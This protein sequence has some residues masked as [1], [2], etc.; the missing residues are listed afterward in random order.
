MAERE[1][2]QADDFR[3]ASGSLRVFGVVSLLVAAS[4]AA[5]AWWVYD[6]YIPR[7]AL[8]AFAMSLMV[9]SG[10]PAIPPS[11]HQQISG[12]TSLRLGVIEL[13][14]HIWFGM[15]VVVALSLLIAGLAALVCSRRA[16]GAHRLAALLIIA[17]TIGT[18][19]GLTVLIN[20]GGF[21]PTPKPL[22]YALIVVIQSA[23][24]WILALTLPAQPARPT[25]Q[26]R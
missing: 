13:T 4:W 6:D 19:V 11:N 20:K 21:P 25:G 22:L 8:E 18:L 14:R 7:R 1:S 2:N 23:Y 3:Q 9:G 15:M 26:E 5:A 10:Q 16:R 12:G 24:G 17:S